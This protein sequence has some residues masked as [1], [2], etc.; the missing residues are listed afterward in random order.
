MAREPEEDD[1]LVFDLVD[2]AVGDDDAAGDDARTGAPD[3]ADE[4]GS[5]TGG[6]LGDTGVLSARLRTLAPFAAVLAMVL[7][8]AYAVDGVREADRVDRIRAVN[9]GAVDVSS[10]LDELWEWKGTV[11]YGGF[12]REG[13]TAQVA[14]LG[15][16]LVFVSAG[17]LLALDT[18]S[19]AE[20]WEV[21]LAEEPE[22]GPVGYPGWEPVATASVV[23]VHGPR[24]DREVVAVGPDGVP[25]ARV[26]DAADTARY[27]TARPG[28]GGT[29]LRARRVGPAAAPDL[30]A[31][32]CRPSGECT[33]TVETGRGIAVRAEDAVTGAERWQVTAPYVATPAAACVLPWDRSWDGLPSRGRDGDLP[34]TETFGAQISADRVDLY[35]C[36]AHASVTSDGALLHEAGEPGDA[37]HIA[38]LSTGGYV[39]LGLRRGTRDILYSA[40][41]EVLETVTDNPFEASVIDGTGMLLGTDTDTGTGESRL[42]AYESDGTPRWAG[43]SGATFVW[44][45]AEAAGTAVLLAE[46]GAVHGLDATTGAERWVWAPAARRDGAPIWSR[47]PHQAF[48]DGR[49]V[50]LYLED[51]AG[52]ATLVSLDAASGRLAW[53]VAMADVLSLRQETPLVAVDGNLLA[54]SAGS[55]RGLG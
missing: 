15:D 5:R 12:G 55:V 47:F 8:T 49:Y 44:F 22:C 9:G 39:A 37:G 31:A 51:E 40:D 42:Q 11:G 43:T 26:L 1:S 41:G 17:D 23:C 36:G 45:A 28:P 7:G 4:P 25:S 20:A 34:D 10:R 13:G 54:V 2:D 14:A 3:G 52:S 21:P 33:G 53:D 19:G 38:S 48:T 29:V 16:L 18:A 50:L 46:D 35:G 32:V 6:L 30:G 27:G 24:T